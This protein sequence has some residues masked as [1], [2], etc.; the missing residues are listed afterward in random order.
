MPR[1]VS[2]PVVRARSLHR[3]VLAAAALLVTAGLG[4]TD[5]WPPDEPRAGAVAEEMRS[6][7]HGW[8]GLV[9]PH[10]NG[11]VYTQKPPLFYWLAALCGALVGRVTETAARL[12]SAAA[13]FLT[14]VLVCHL[15]RVM[16]RPRVGVLAG[17][18]VLAVPSFVLL[19]RS[20]RLDALLT[21]FVVSAFTAL[22][23][24]DRGL[25]NERTNRVFLHAAIGLGVLTKGPVAF[26]F[27]ALGALA[28]LAW[29]RRLGAYRRF[30][31][32][33]TLA[34]SLGPGIAWA[35]AAVA[36]APGGFADEA[37]LR[38]LVGRFFGGSSHAR[39][40]WFYL[41]SFPMGVMPLTLLW[42]LAW[43]RFRALARDPAAAETLRAWRFL[44]API[45]AVFV[46]LSLSAG[47]R[48]VYLAPIE[49]LV[50]L[51]CA[52]ALASWLE[53]DRA[54]VRLRRLPGQS[55]VAA[56]LAAV[57]VLQ[58]GWL[59][60]VQPALNRRNSPRAVA[61]IAGQATPDHARIGLFRHASLVGP[62]QYYGGRRVLL[63]E[64]PDDVGRFFADGGTALVID[65]AQMS[66]LGDAWDFRV[67][68]RERVRQRRILVLA[69]SDD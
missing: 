13:G 3:W 1:P 42:P 57:V 43:L 8:R 9:V 25:G 32:P 24:I 63:L 38:N 36:L 37:L 22:W 50:A 59:L 68:G 53:T 27:P 41:E 47:K 6:F 65:E 69:P 46:F 14:V 56:L 5:F 51:A 30:V 29:E 40:W 21:L 34:L 67:L 58:G 17:I 18:L 12:P 28:W 48:G 7:V 55:A 26:L 66:L 64:E 10:L 62:L 45:G 11:E 23:R 44:L 61:E 31:S 4:A 19:A 15:G 39:P 54:T 33:A 35:A 60:G 52:D 20:A 2:N 16:F 49:P